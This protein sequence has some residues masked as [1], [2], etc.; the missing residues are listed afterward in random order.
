ML[1]TSNILIR[2]LY[3]LHHWVLL[4]VYFVVVVVNIVILIGVLVVSNYGLIFISL[5]TNDV[6]N[7]FICLFAIHLSSLIKCLFKSLHIFKI[8]LSSSL[9]VI[10]TFYMFQ[11]KSFNRYVFCKYFLPLCGSFITLRIFFEELKF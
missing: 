10:R 1:T 9:W 2:S 11:I 3:Y 8:V 6:E 7:L 5:V 4:S